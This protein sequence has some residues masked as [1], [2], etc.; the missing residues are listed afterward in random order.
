MIQGVN[1]PGGLLFLFPSWWLF[2]M[3]LIGLGKILGMVLSLLIPLP[4][5][6]LGLALVPIDKGGSLAGAGAGGDGEILLEG[7]REGVL[8]FIMLLESVDSGS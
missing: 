3:I 4:F 6:E 7:T 2:P 5:D 8:V 1:P